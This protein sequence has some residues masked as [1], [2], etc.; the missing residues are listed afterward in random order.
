MCV[1][2]LSAMW[3]CVCWEESWDEGHEFLQ[4][5]VP[6]L[7]YSLAPFLWVLLYT[8]R[9]PSSPFL[10]RP[11]EI[12]GI[13]L[14]CSHFACSFSLIYL[15]GQRHWCWRILSS[16]I[17]WYSVLIFYSDTRYFDK[18]A[19]ALVCTCLSVAGVWEGLS[20]SLIWSHGSVVVLSN[21]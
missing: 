4:A 11:S 13:P 6:L 17:F 9:S 3:G 10:L 5:S 18:G 20:L 7:W 12:K 8:M 19:Q 21:G 14:C 1:L 2:H 15:C 16:Q